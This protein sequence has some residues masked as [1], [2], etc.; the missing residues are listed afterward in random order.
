MIATV[1][2]VIVVV[3]I[4]S[5]TIVSLFDRTFLRPTEQIRVVIEEIMYA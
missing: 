1:I 5:A 2:F 3:V 4:V